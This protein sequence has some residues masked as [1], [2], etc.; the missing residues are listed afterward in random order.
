MKNE[1][2]ADASGIVIDLMGNAKFKKRL[3]EPEL[4]SSTGAPTD[5]RNLGTALS[6]ALEPA[7]DEKRRSG[8]RP[9]RTDPKG[10]VLPAGIRYVA[11][12]PKLPYR[13]EQEVQQANGSWR[14]T[15]KSFPTLAAAKKGLANLKLTIAQGNPPPGQRAKT[16]LADFQEEVQGAVLKA[17]RT[18]NTL[19]DYDRAWRIRILPDLGNYKLGDIS[20]DVVEEVIQSWLESATPSTVCSA[21]TYLSQLLDKAVAQNRIRKNPLQ[22]VERPKSSVTTNVGERA[23]TAR[24]QAALLR[25][26]QKQ[27]P[28]YDWFIQTLL[29]TGLRFNE[30]TALRVADVNLAAGVLAVN[31]A[32]FLDENGSLKVGQTKGKKCRAAPIPDSLR[33]ALQAAMQG[34]AQDEQLLTTPGGATIRGSN[35][36]RSLNWDSIRRSIGKPDMCFHDLRHTAVSNMLSMGIPLHDVR[37]ILGHSDVATTNAYSGSHSDYASRA[38]R[39][40][41]DQWREFLQ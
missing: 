23:L 22:D 28:A 1:Q 27:D 39:R 40:I 10:Y 34:K 26:M 11:S 15:S 35:L 3:M 38:A 5:A 36:R 12:R 2:L 8:R 21:L 4:R 37:A 29:H 33:P 13:V 24:Q 20:S 18:P 19:R 25:I 6:P 30:A 16:S 7:Q 41:N 17:G 9:A 14:S 32:Y 31:R